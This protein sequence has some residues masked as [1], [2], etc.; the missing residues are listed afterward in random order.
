METVQA[1]FRRFAAQMLA[2]FPLF[3]GVL[4]YDLMRLP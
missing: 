3:C 2:R 1:E 4:K